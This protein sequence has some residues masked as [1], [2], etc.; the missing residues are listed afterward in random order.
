MIK[1]MRQYNYKY[2]YSCNFYKYQELSQKI[3]YKN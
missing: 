2:D 3:F 1:L